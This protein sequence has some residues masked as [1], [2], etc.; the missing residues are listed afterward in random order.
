MFSLDNNN[1]N[2]LEA[3]APKSAGTAPLG[4]IAKLTANFSVEAQ[5]LRAERFKLLKD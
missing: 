4:T 1:E 2:E 5:R 3:T